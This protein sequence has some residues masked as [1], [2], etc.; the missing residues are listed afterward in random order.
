MSRM[1]QLLRMALVLCALQLRAESGGLR[2][3]GHSH[4]Q[5][6]LLLVGA[7]ILSRT[8]LGYQR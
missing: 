6:Q 3:G 2:V 4:V 5:V 1:D 7:S 8:V